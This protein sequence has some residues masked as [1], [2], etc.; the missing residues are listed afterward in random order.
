MV[1]GE[2]V[3]G[4]LT[5]TVQPPSDKERG[6]DLR[7]RVVN[8]LTLAE[9]EGI[10]TTTNIAKAVGC[11]KN[12]LTVVLRGV[13]EDGVIEMVKDGKADVYRIAREDTPF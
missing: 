8:A 3:D 7:E 4:L 9:P 10:R 13:I 12:D 5:L 1:V 11:K 2:H 6:A